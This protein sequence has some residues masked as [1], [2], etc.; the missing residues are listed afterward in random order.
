MRYAYA[1]PNSYIYFLNYIDGIGQEVNILN[2][3]NEHQEYIINSPDH[4]IQVVKLFEQDSLIWGN[5]KFDAKH[6]GGFHVFVS[7]DHDIKF[8]LY[9]DDLEYRDDFFQLR[10]TSQPAKDEF[11][12]I[13][14]K[15]EK[16]LLSGWIPLNRMALKNWLGID[17]DKYIFSF[18]GLSQ[19][20]SRER[21]FG[22]KQKKNNYIELV[23]QFNIMIKKRKKLWRI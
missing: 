8:G 11:I 1:K 2:L 22:K 15:Q 13:S 7:L 4:E 21:L 12:K 3:G 10:D 19:M 9:G 18:E 14:D 20:F 23:N 17:S 16:S 5:K 6:L